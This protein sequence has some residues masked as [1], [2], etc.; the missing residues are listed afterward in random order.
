MTKEKMAELKIKVPARWVNFIEECYHVNGLDR[1]VDLR[2]NVRAL[3]EM[4]T[5]EL[6]T[7]D[8]VRLHDKYQLSDIRK[9]SQRTRDEAAGIPRKV[10]PLDLQ[11][12]IVDKIVTILSNKPEFEEARSRHFKLAIKES[13]AALTPG[14]IAE[15]QAAA[16]SA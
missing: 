2:D 11:T 12:G 15:I 4:L 13:I 16:S 7:K 9:I 10:E 3:V 14:E 1:N 8:L 5:D 6:D